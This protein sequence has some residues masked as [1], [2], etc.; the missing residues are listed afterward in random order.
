MK[1]TLA[2]LLI[3]SLLVVTVILAIYRPPS[4]FYPAVEIEATEPLGGITLSFLFEGR[5][6]LSDCEL[7]TGNI[8][9]K[10]LQACPQC[11]ITKLT[12][13]FTLSQDSRTHLSDAPIQQPSGRM[14]NGV[15]IYRSA[16]TALAHAACHATESQSAKSL[17]PVKCYNPETKRKLLPAPS[18]LNAW[19]PIVLF[20]ALLSAWLVGWLIIR[21]EHL[22]AHFSHDYT[23][24]GPQ[25]Y[26]TQPTPRIGGL[27]V[28]V[29]LL[30]A[31]GI[32]LFADAISVERQF[33][34]LLLA[35][36]PA[37]L[38]GLI[39]D[40]TKKVGVLERLLL[41]MLSGA[42]AAWLLGAVLNRLDIPGVDAALTWLPFAVAF[43][44]FAV[45]GIANAINIID[46]YNGLAGGFAVIVLAAIAYVAN[47]V[48]DALVF[49]T[50]IALV[51]AVVG[52]LV[53]NWPCG[54]IFFGDGGAYLVG[55][56]LAEL[57]ILLVLRNPTVSPW[58]PLLLLI[59]PIFETIYSI[60]RRKFQ[61]KLSPGQPDN[62]HLHQLIHDKL[63]PH[64][65]HGKPFS[66]NS[67]V[68]KYL[69]IPASVLAALGSIFSG[70]T[71]FLTTCAVGFCIFYILNYRRISA[72]KR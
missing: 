40:I 5:S 27:A 32:M 67:Q 69:W 1:K 2:R 34:L 66:R 52:F 19:S 35:G 21:Y 42:A 33:G 45:G 55:F 29:G 68:A 28:M 25:K 61:H 18:P 43:T 8:A 57:S 22:H 11:R 31:G 3:A 38:G 63:I 17:S 26:H 51:G 64:H 12:C 13:D 46:G 56:M 15:I 58:F 65:T 53:W 9:R 36:I 41:T 71:P 10:T 37:F 50:S 30:S 14:T 4:N 49:N 48:G 54:K 7:A 23:N 16:N 70:S 62:Q 59:Y 47:T 24:S 39:E 20:I 72:S 60:Y 44:A 6:T